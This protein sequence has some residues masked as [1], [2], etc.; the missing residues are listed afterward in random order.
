M[1]KSKSS[2]SRSGCKDPGLVPMLLHTSKR[3]YKLLVS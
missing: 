2:Q 3:A 1:K